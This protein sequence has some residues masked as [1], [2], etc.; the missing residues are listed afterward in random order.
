MDKFY[1]VKSSPNWADEIDFE[2]F[3]LFSEDEYQNELAKFK[4]LSD[5]GRS[6]SGYCGSNE[7]YE[8]S[9]SQ[10]LRD[11]E[12]AKVIDI[13]EHAFLFENFGSHYGTTHYE[14]W[15]DLDCDEDED[16]DEDEDEE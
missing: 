15:D 8:V 10:V 16:Y 11:L 3:D 12:R 2:G 14:W 7:E 13:D 4:K 1:L 9:A 6:C 5:D